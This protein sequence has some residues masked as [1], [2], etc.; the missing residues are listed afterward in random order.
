[1]AERGKMKR[2]RLS[3]NVGQKGNSVG[4]SDK[5]GDLWLH[6][7]EEGRKSEQIYTICAYSTQLTTSDIHKCT[8]TNTSLSLSSL[9]PA[10]HHSALLT[11]TCTL[12]LAKSSPTLFKKKKCLHTTLPSQGPAQYQFPLYQFPLNRKTSSDF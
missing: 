11:H 12:S 8:H 1:M 5:D 2:S 9:K 10:A 6:C 4:F 7:F 3:L